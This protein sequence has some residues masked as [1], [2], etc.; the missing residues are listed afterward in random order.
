MPVAGTFN[1]R[2]ATPP[3]MVGVV[4]ELVTLTYGDGPAKVA[5]IVSGPKAAV[6]A[7][8]VLYKS[9]TVKLKG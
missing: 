2:L 7:A 8:A 4:V 9:L 6:A 3:A 5:D 1:T